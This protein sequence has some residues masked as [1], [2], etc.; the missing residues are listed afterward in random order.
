MS[1]IERPKSPPLEAG[2]R[3]DRA[4]FHARY[5]AMPPGTRAE[6]IG[7]VVYM[8]SPLGL[9]H[10]DS[11]GSTV[12]WLKHYQRSTPGVQALSNASLLLDDQAEPQ[13]DVGLRIRPEC[14]GQSRTEGKYIGGAP[15]LVVEVTVTTRKVD[16]G[17]KFEDYRRA[18]VLEY[19][20]VARD[21]DEVRWFVRR[22]D[23]L[24]PLPPGPDG[25][26]RSEVFPGL[27]L[28][29][30]ALLIDD[31]D[32]LIATLEQGLATAVH[33]AFVARLAARRAAPPEGA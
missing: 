23:R 14:G 21:P 10:S 13:P 19:I 27:W 7:G 31:M 12:Y 24:E 11:D 6:L 30:D 9:D 29:A 4:T 17:P 1:T 15:E 33:A 32:R 2:Q 28:D 3:L 26:Y 20:V 25:V 5:E 16:L 8:P 18:G 22:D